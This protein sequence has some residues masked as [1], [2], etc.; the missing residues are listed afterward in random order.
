MRKKAK[1]LHTIAVSLQKLVA[2]QALMSDYNEIAL[3]VKLGMISEDVGAAL[4]K[5][6][7]TNFQSLMAEIE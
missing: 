7:I 4:V 1:D 3:K 5:G 6:S 2:I